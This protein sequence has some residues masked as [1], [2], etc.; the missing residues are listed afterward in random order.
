MIGKKLMLGAAALAALGMSGTLAATAGSGG[1][2]GPFRGRIRQF[3]VGRLGCLAALR[4]DLGLTDE[5]RGKIAAAVRERKDQVGPVARKLVERRR[6][7]RDAVLEPSPDEQKI[8]EAAAKLGE[9]IGDAA[10][11]ASQ[12]VGD[13][14][15]VLTDEQRKRIDQARADHDKAV[16]GLLKEIFGE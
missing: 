13:V 5:Q 1:E 14:R 7:L 9:A 10:V 11:L 8:R 2:G 12:V 15:P 6:A 16:D 4:A 3:V